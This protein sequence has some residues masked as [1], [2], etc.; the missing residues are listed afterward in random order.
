MINDLLSKLPGFEQD[1]I[2][3]LIAY[4]DLKLCLDVGAAAGV[5]TRWIKDAGSDGTRV[6][7]FEPF[8]G[9]HSYFLD[10]TKTLSNIELVKKAAAAQTGTSSFRVL[11]TVQGS[12]KGWESMQGYSSTGALI[13]DVNAQ[14]VHSAAGFQD[15][16]VDTVA[17]AD[18]VDEHV[19]FMKI[20]VQG[21]ELDVI[22]G[23]EPIIR[24]HGIDVMYVE[25]DGDRRIIEFLT[26]LGYSIFDTDYLLIPKGDDRSLLDGIG[27]YDF[28]VL[29]LS[30][31]RKAYRAKL[32]VADGDYCDFYNNVRDN[33]GQIYTDLICVSEPFLGSFFKHFMAFSQRYL[34]AQGNTPRSMKAIPRSLGK[35]FPKKVAPPP[36]P[37]TPSAPPAPT[38]SPTTQSPAPPAPTTSAPTTSAPTTSAPTTSAPTTLSPTPT[39]LTP[40][41]TPSNNKIATAT[42]APVATATAVEQEPVPPK[43]D[44][45]PQRKAVKAEPIAKNTKNVKKPAQSSPVSA[46]PA[47]MASKEPSSAMTAMLGRILQYY[48]R[49]PVVL[50]SVA[51]ALN[52]VAFGAQGLLG[53]PLIVLGTL[54]VLFLV[55]HAASKADYV[56]A[57][58]QMV[59]AE[60][61]KTIATLNRQ[62]TRLKKRQKKG[63]KGA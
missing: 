29:N 39:A 49:W 36:I 21:G 8:P 56:L 2:Y 28:K 4:Q 40:S 44:P 11:S 43:K 55:G 34:D 6:I 53:L 16:N 60:H 59:N 27:F 1:I 30:T 5:T 12:E 23:C 45:M 18:L 48:S 31:G 50:A 52:A 62:V 19:D 17:I 7:G 51:I 33:C 47:P 57:E 42:I 32:S 35:P 37:L 25:F 26:S 20:D 58:L 61:Q 14:P 41:S 38:P 54:I 63:Q 9:N 24:K 22:K 15:L 46:A 3:K 10:H 13:D